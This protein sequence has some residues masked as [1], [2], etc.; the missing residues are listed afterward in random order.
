MTKRSTGEFSQNCPPSYKQWQSRFPLSA[1]IEKLTSKRC[2]KLQTM[3]IMI[4]TFSW[5]GKTQ[6]RKL[7]TKSTIGNVIQ[8]DLKPNGAPR[9]APTGFSQ[10]LK[11]W[12][13]IIY[14]LHFAPSRVVVWGRRG[15]WALLTAAQVWKL[16]EA[17][18][19]FLL[20]KWHK[21][22]A[23]Y[24]E[25]GKYVPPCLRRA[26][27]VYLKI[28]GN[29]FKSGANLVSNSKDASKHRMSS[30]KRNYFGI[31]NNIIFLYWNILLFQK[32]KNTISFQRE[33]IR[34]LKKKTLNIF[35]FQI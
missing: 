10:Q 33:K 13:K 17:E 6:L 14:H 2:V 21:T 23:T 34:F 4:P 15:E 8:N 18:A 25:A 11:M 26:F 20:C 12:F 16:I 29:A 30:N 24:G 7:K 9:R 19:D 32:T 1:G 5:Y 28:P 31:K 22:R 27:Q 35:F 3:T